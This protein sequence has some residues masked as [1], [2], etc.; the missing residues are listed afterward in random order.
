MIL[1]IDVFVGIYIHSHFLVNFLYE[2]MR[3][4]AGAETVGRWCY[5][6]QERYAAAWC[7]IY[8]IEYYC[9]YEAGSNAA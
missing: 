7:R 9:F 5:C 8:A 1:N 3:G 4:V 2:F 6:L